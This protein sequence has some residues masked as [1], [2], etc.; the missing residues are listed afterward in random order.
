MDIVDRLLNDRPAFHARGEKRWDSLPETLRAIE[1]SVGKDDLTLET[2]CGA[3]TVV[4]AY[5]GARHTTISPDGSEH[6]AVRAYLEKVG[7]QSESVQFNE[8]YSDLVLPAL[9]TDRLL[10][11]A[12]IDGAH[13]F[14]Y[15]IV[16]WH[17]ITRALKL[18]GRL[19]VDDIPI[20]SVACLYRYMR[21]DPAWRLDGILDE[22]AAAF[23]LV[24]EPAPEDWVLQPFNRWPDYG[25]ARLPARL[26]LTVTAEATR[27]RENLALRHPGLRRAWRSLRDALG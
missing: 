25:F 23:T 17:Y 11:A 4:F 20:P 27:V 22:R 5:Q 16:D 2:G 21:S 10:D 26:R 7:V 13:S 15:P 6:A 9:C 18:G 8:G 12:F 3:S 14:P 1:R 19:I 24:S